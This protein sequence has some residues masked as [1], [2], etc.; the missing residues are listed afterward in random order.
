MS[1]VDDFEDDRSSRF[2]DIAVG[3]VGKVLRKGLARS[4]IIDTVEAGRVVGVF[5]SWSW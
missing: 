1:S 4:S 3:I 5:V 2:C